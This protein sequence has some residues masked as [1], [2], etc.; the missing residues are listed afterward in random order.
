[1]S[2]VLD[3]LMRE[4]MAVRVSRIAKE[5]QTDA[6]DLER[7]GVRGG[8]KMAAQLRAVAVQLDPAQTALE[9]AEVHVEVSDDGADTVTIRY[10]PKEAAE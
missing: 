10:K 6:L 2:E 4:G 7:L 5:L 9:F 3:R 8:Y 1:M